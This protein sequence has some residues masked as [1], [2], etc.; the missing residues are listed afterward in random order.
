MVRKFLLVCGIL[1]AIVY[2]AANIIVPARW[3]AYDW[4]S[5]TVSELS[6]VDAPTRALW[7][8]LVIPYGILLVAFGAG[9]RA[10][11]NQYRGLRIAGTLIILNGII[12]FTWPPM[13]SREVLAAGGGT[14]TDTMHIVYTIVNALLMFGAMGFSM[15]AFGKRYRVYCIATVLVELAFGAVTAIQ[16]SSMQANLPTPLMG[17]WERIIIVAMMTWFAVLAVAILRRTGTGSFAI[18]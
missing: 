14:L 16:S 6:A 11:A 12:G 8:A 4:M 18:S 17:V 13:H 7:I 2:M 9:V 15:T 1:S 5:Q 3:D 10:S